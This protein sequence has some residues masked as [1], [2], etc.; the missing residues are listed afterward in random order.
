MS[1]TSKSRD[2]WDRRA[3]IYGRQLA[4][5]QV[6]HNR[7]SNEQHQGGQESPSVGWTPMPV[8]AVDNEIRVLATTTSH[9]C[10]TGHR[11]GEARIGRLGIVFA[12]D[13]SSLAR[14]NVG[15]CRSEAERKACFRPDEAVAAA[16]RTVFDP[17]AELGF[18]RQS[19]FWFGSQTPAL[20]MPTRRAAAL[21][22]GGV[23][24]PLAGAGSNRRRRA[25]S[26]DRG[27]ACLAPSHRQSPRGRGGRS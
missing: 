6:S 11:N 20:L 16:G 26:Q 7:E 8:Q 5:V 1:E 3:R 25:L 19:S 14:N 22:I 10:G 4:S 12:F 27:E 13:G 17:F 23:R 2:P 18:A 21:G 9:G 24:E 15:W